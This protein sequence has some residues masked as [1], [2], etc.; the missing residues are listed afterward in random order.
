MWEYYAFLWT[1]QLNFECLSLDNT[2]VLTHTCWTSEQ[3][4]NI[5]MKQTFADKCKILHQY[6]FQQKRKVYK[7]L[8]NSSAPPYLELVKLLYRASYWR[9]TTS[10]FTTMFLLLEDCKLDIPVL[11]YASI[12]ALYKKYP[13]KFLNFFL[14]HVLQFS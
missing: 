4:K 12:L 6:L 14:S 7:F 10:F 13:L 5:F 11:S 2:Y 9:D 1:L 8:K 3:V